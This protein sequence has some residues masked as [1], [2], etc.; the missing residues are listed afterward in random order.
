RA[1]SP[2]ASTGQHVV[3]DPSVS[4]TPQLAIAAP[5]APPPSG[6]DLVWVRES[7]FTSRFVAIDW[8]GMPR[9]VLV[10]PAGSGDPHPS[11]S[12][13][14]LFTQE[15]TS[16]TVYRAD[17]TQIGLFSDPPGSSST[18]KWADDDDHLCGLVDQTPLKDGSDEVLFTDT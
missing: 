8:S 12:G 17:G 18:W 9:G 6:V 4:A 7:S 15:D 11:P 2:P 5:Q 1:T 16:T 13:R 3:G 14:R 10:L